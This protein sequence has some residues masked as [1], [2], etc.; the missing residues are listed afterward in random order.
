MGGFS[1]LFDSVRTSGGGKL[2]F[3]FVL[4][5]LI[6]GVI[7]SWIIIFYNKKIVGALV[8]AIISSGATSQEMAKTLAEI[9]QEHNVSAI[10]HYKRSAALQR[11]ILIAGKSEPP[12][13]S[14]KKKRSVTIDE[15]TRFYIPEDMLFRAEKQY[16]EEEHGV[17]SIV[18][19]TVAI[20]IAGVII[21]Y[22]SLT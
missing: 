5:T 15:S 18:L 21:T 10:S 1:E 20:I 22:I 12:Q 13:E 6:F 11:I 9:E 3:Q 16:G 19:G 14:G 4:W 8:R 2:S 7:I 17:L